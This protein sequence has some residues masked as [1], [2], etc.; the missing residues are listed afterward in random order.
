MAKTKGP[1]FSLKA[2][3]SIGG[4]ITFQGGVGPQQAHIKT[5]PTDKRSTSQIEKRANVSLAATE[6]SRE[7]Q[8]IKDLFD[9]LAPDKNIISGYNL[10]QKIFLLF[11]NDWIRFNGAKFNG[12]MY[13]GP[14]N[15]LD[16]I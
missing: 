14:E 9:S 4:V 2:Q 1:L 13:G 3:G 10:Y 7:S 12:A 11:Y 5:T 16:K 8:T 6:Y 15:K